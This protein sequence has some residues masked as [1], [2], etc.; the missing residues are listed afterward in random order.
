ME[1][2]TV[3]GAVRW[4]DGLLLSPQ[5]FQQ[6]FARQD[7]LLDH[8]VAAVQPWFWGLMDWA[9]LPHRLADGVFQIE[10]LSAVMPD[11]LVVEHLSDDPPLMLDLAPC[12][13]GLADRPLTLWLAVA[14]QFPGAPPQGVPMRYVEDDGPPVA[15]IHTGEG[16]VVVPRLRPALRLLA[17]GDVTPA[18]TGFPLACISAR[19]NV[20]SLTPFLPPLLQVPVGSPL[21]QSCLELA[22]SLRDKASLLVDRVTSPTAASDDPAVRDARAVISVL[23]APLPPF[24]AVALTGMAHPFSLYIALLDV[25]GRLAALAPDMMPPTWEAYNHND[26]TATFSGPLDFARRMI[27]GVHEVSRPVSFRR[28]GGRF[29]LTLRHEWLRPQGLVIGVRRPAGASD[30]DAASWVRDAIVASDSRI[31]SMSAHRTRGADRVV[32]DRD[33]DLRLLPGRGQTLFRVMADPSAMVGGEPLV[34]VNRADPDGNRAPAEV[35]LFVTADD[36]PVPRTEART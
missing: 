27:G 7:A 28:S 16:G 31:E 13:A 12:R 2:R 5:H 20:L 29:E 23:T 22:R 10:H 14:R 26:L 15:D 18:Y 30:A 9:F 4:H 25:V 6:A 8:R 33:D 21:G 32:I 3:P 35:V 11:G 36:P 17:A 1:E 34:I 19:D 24:E